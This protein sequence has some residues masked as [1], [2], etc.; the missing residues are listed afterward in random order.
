MR[1]RFRPIGRDSGQTRVRIERSAKQRCYPAL[2]RRAV[3]TDHELRTIS[4]PVRVG[5]Q[6]WRD[7]GSLPR[8]GRHFELSGAPPHTP[9]Q[10]SLDK[11]EAA[12]LDRG[13]VYRGAVSKVV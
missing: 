12:E 3:D 11:E 8:S 1:V 5:L 6:R 13:D 7:H 2:E 10:G 4:R 9:A